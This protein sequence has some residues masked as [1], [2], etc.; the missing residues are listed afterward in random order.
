MTRLY[1]TKLLPVA[2]K[3]YVGSLAN[4]H[5]YC[6]LVLDTLELSFIDGDLGN[7]QKKMKG[8]E[9]CHLIIIPHFKITYVTFILVV[10][11]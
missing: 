1:R 5:L 8:I 3:I 7:T 6:F 11:Y 4:P 9:I 2:H 10:G